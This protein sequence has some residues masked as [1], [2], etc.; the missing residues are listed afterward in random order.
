MQCPE[1]LGK[2]VAHPC[3]SSNGGEP[4]LPGKFT[5]GAEQRQLGDGMRHTNDK[6]VFFPFLSCYSQ[7]FCSTVLLKF[8]WIPELSQSSFCSRMAV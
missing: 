7:G 6:A 2:L 3:N 5:F 8:K 4:S 1:R